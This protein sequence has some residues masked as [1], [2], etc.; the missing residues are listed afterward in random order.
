ML[1][2]T[3][4]IVLC[5]RTI[6]EN[7]KFIDFLTKDYGLI[8]ISVKGANKLTSKNASS[9]QLFSY[10]KICVQKRGQRYYLNSSEIIRTFYKIRLDI[11]KFALASYFSELLKYSV[12]SEQS[13]DEI[14]RLVL[15]TFH[16]LEEEKYPA[17]QLKSIFELRFISEIG[18]MPD[19]LA[20]KNCIEFESE[21]MYLFLNEGYLLCA[22]C[23]KNLENDNREVFHLDAS[24][25]HT[26]R[27]ILLSDF[28]KIYKFK[29]SDNLL[30]ELN[31]FSEKFLLCHLDRNF[32]TLEFYHSL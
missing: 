12:P 23:Y 26:I 30:E 11:K 25:L 28:N 7:D 32:K 27:F 29:I 8:E 20:C 3:E 16:F 14:L 2:T 6:K 13:S 9:T 19:I 21:K 31:C 24:L 22:K 5:E 4:G 15:N 10:S 1:I 18:I 17:Q